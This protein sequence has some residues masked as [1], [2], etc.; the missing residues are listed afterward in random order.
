MYWLSVVVAQV[1]AAVDTAV[2]HLAGAMGKPVWLLVQDSPDWRW[3]LNR[4]DSPWYPTLR[5]F[6]QSHRGDWR[7]LMEQ[8]VTELHA[9]A[10]GEL[11]IGRRRVLDHDA[12]PRGVTGRIRIEERIGGMEPDRH[13]TRG[14]DAGHAAYVIKVR[15][16]EPDGFE[17]TAGGVH[18]RQQHVRL[19]TGIDQDRLSAD[20]IGQQPAVLLQRANGELPQRERAHGDVESGVSGTGA[21][22]VASTGDS[23]MP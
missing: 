2:A 7:P 8:V 5:L 9:I 18:G 12:P 11:M 20:C 22:V 15:V 3:Q 21:S 17:R 6:R 19:I 1:V 23:P 13:R 16:G 14:D 4:A 10:F